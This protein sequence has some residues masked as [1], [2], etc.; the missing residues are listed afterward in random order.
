MQKLKYLSIIISPSFQ[1][2]CVITARTTRIYH[3]L[4]I[5][6]HRARIVSDRNLAS[7]VGITTAQVSVLSVLAATGSASQVEVAAQ[8]KLR[9][10]AITPMVARLL[11][12]G[13]I[14]RQRDKSDRR[15]WRLTLTEAGE[16]L[17]QAAKPPFARIN[18]IVD[19]ALSEEEIDRLAV[20]LAKLVE[21]FDLEGAAFTDNDIEGHEACLPA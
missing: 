15:S 16:S 7:D 1:G 4:Q 13:L 21:A 14:D 18:R 19:S 10:A 20:L 17:L 6:A 12:N 9:E 3:W 2:K 8:L 11:G 5:A